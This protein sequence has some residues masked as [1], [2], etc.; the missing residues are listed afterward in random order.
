MPPLAFIKVPY[1]KLNAQKQEAFN[2]QKI[3]S[4]LADFGC[5]TIPL[6]N[7]W[8]G[9]DFI[10]QMHDGV[11]FHKVQLKGGLTFDIR[12]LGKHLYICLRDA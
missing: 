1:E 2:F 11:T 3:S 10:V 9:A 7:D 12:Y 6:S 8:N 5:L 4:V